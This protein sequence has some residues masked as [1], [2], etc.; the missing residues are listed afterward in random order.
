MAKK[1]RTKKL[2]V[3]RAVKRTA[4]KQ[5]VRFKGFTVARRKK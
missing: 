3:M 1:R 5:A 2:A 4:A